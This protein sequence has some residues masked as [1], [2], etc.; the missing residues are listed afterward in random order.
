MKHGLKLKIMMAY[1]LLSILGS[2]VRLRILD[3]GGC[4]NEVGRRMIFSTKTRRLNYTRGGPL[5]GT[6]RH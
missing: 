4:R 6:R 1:E 3:E 2:K 5:R